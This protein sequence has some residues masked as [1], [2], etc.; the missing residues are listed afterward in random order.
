MSL[1]YKD[2]DAP[3]HRASKAVRAAL[4]WS[5]AQFA[6]RQ[7]PT[8]NANVVDLHWHAASALCIHQTT[9]VGI[10]GRCFGRGNVLGAVYDVGR[11][12]DARVNAG[13]CGRVLGEHNGCKDGE[14]RDGGV[15]EGDADHVVSS[16]LLIRSGL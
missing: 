9:S 14:E 11:T 4:S 1:W 13:G 6:P 3:L 2:H 8:V 10:S 16:V 5:A 15:E 12:A 7:F